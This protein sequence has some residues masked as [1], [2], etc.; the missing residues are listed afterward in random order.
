MKKI[1]F[2]NK[3]SE[4]CSKSDKLQFKDVSHKHGS[5]TVKGL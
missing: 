3:M 5:G 2:P 1:A 4:V